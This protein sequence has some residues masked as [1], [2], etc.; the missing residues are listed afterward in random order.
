MQLKSSVG[1]LNL[2][3]LRYNLDARYIILLDD[4]GNESSISF[5]NSDCQQQGSKEQA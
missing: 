3:K 2:Q 1:D 4:L 5:N